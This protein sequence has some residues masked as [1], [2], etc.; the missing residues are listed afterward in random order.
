MPFDSRSFSGFR[1]IGAALEEAADGVETCIA[2]RL[3]KGGDDSSVAAWF[4][5]DVTGSVRLRFSVPVDL[6]AGQIVLAKGALVGGVFGV[7]EYE[8]HPGLMPDPAS[9]LSGIPERYILDP[10]SAGTAR[11]RMDVIRKAR[12]FLFSR[13]YFE[14]D[15]P[16]LYSSPGTDLNIEAFSTGYTPGMDREVKQRDFYLHTSP[17]LAMKRL[18]VSGFPA[19]FQV[20]RVYRNGEMGDIHQPEFIMAEWYRVGISYIELM[21]ELELMLSGPFG[22]KS[23]FERRTIRDIFMATIGIDPLPPESRDMFAEYIYNETGDRYP[24]E[25]SWEDLFYRI[26][27]D[28]IEPWICSRPALFVYDY[29]ARVAVLARLKPGDERVAER[30]ELYVRGVELAN[31]FSELTDAAE[32]RARFESDLAGRKLAGRELYPMPESFLESLSLGLPPCAGVSLGLDRLAMLM[33]EE[34]NLAGVLPFVFGK[35]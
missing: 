29:P 10:S 16:S 34:E 7:R 20:C 21:D 15:T 13:G 14:V 25:A 6:S 22:F 1:G 12:E 28:Y 11:L 30:F 35:T 3:V 8:S 26:M 19:I 27:V 17:E 2:G 32:Q 31:G 9:G 18:L 23:P 4:L 24:A 5:Q 33:A